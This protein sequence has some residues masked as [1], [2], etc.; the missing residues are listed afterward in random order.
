MMIE[1]STIPLYLYAMY[2]IKL[3]NGGPGSQA[4]TAI[5]GFKFLLLTFSIGA[6]TTLLQGIVEQEMLHLTLDG[7]LLSALDGFLDLYDE[8]VMPIYPS[9]ILLQ[10]VPMNLDRTSKEN[11]DCFLQVLCVQ[12]PLA[13]GLLIN[14]HRLRPRILLVLSQ[15]ILSQD[16][17]RR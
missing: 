17:F 11:L 3:D 10:K 15:I 12:S 1:L 14:I 16:C 13:W 9:E 2:S 6:L 8:S 7:N 5:K 4:R